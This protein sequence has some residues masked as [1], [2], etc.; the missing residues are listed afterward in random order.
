M[1]WYTDGQIT[2]I[3]CGAVQGRNETA[4]F[5]YPNLENMLYRR[6]AEPMPAKYIVINELC[7]SVFQILLT[8]RNQSMFSSKGTI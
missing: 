7:P 8:E 5:I 2:I 3:N 1:N 4:C 6:A